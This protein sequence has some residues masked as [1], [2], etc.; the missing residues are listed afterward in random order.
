[1]KHS[2]RVTAQAAQTVLWL[3][4]LIGLGGLVILVPALAGELTA[5]FSQYESD[6]VILVALLGLPVLIGLA[7]LGLILVLLRRI[8]L[9]K[10]LAAATY[11]PIRWLVFASALLAGSFVLIGIWLTMKN[12]LPP[13][14]AIV[15]AVFALVSLTVSL[16]TSVLF[17]LLKQAVAHSDELREVI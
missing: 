1:M 8:R 15:L 6:F 17:G 2:S 13:V 11:G 10:M 4:I 3:L 9:D 14:I 16:V 7:I 12:T 5:E